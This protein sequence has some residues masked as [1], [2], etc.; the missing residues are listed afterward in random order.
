[1]N[2]FEVHHK[3][4]K[5]DGVCHC[6][7]YEEKD[8][9]TDST[10]VVVDFTEENTINVKALCVLFDLKLPNFGEPDSETFLENIHIFIKNLKNRVGSQDNEESASDVEIFKFEEDSSESED[11]GSFIGVETDVSPI[12]KFSEEDFRRDLPSQRTMSLGSSCPRITRI[13][14]KAMQDFFSLRGHSKDELESLEKTRI[15]N[16]IKKPK[17]NL[18][19]SFSPGKNASFLK[20]KRRNGGFRNRK[21]SIISNS[22]QFPEPFRVT[23]EKDDLKSSVFKRISSYQISEL[24]GRTCTTVANQLINSEKTFACIRNEPESVN[25]IEKCIE[26]LGKE[27]KLNL[28]KNLKRFGLNVPEWIT[29]CDDDLTDEIYKE[30]WGNYGETLRSVT[31][32]KAAVNILTNS[33]PNLRSCKGEER[34]KLATFVVWKFIQDGKLK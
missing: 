33:C 23:L 32:F 3:G 16:T 34:S 26:Q 7:L 28:S 11:D 21:G 18:S 9:V 27:G 2:T 6:E 10:K 25:K 4:A 24:E 31:S 5:F 8:S 29:R 14:K 20:N 17:S 12:M 13:S 22:H 1:M 30:I 15:T 19:Q